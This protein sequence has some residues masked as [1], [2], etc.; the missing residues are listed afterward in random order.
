MWEVASIVR[1]APDTVSPPWVHSV[2]YISTTREQLERP[3]VAMSG[4]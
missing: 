4:A 2:G 3:R 1:L